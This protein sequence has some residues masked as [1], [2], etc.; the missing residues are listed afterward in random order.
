MKPLNI[1]IG[2][3]VLADV[4]NCFDQ[5]GS[6]NKV[7]I[8]YSKNCKNLKNNN[9]LYWLGTKNIFNFLIPPVFSLFSIF[10]VS[11]A[12]IY[13]Y[14]NNDNSSLLKTKN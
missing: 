6:S 10:L 11:T 12:F 3:S 5:L 9:Y 2:N 1:K 7:K 8:I 14:D 13:L 4:I